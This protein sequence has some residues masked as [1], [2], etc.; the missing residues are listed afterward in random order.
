[1][2]RKR[3]LRRKRRPPSQLRLPWWTQSRHCPKKLKLAKSLGMTK[4]PLFIIINC[5]INNK[6]RSKWPAIQNSQLWGSWPP[7]IIKDWTSISLR[8]LILMISVMFHQIRR[9]L[10][11]HLAA[12]LAPIKS[13]NYR[14]L[15][16]FRWRSYQLRTLNNRD[17]WIFKKTAK[18]IL[19]CHQLFLVVEKTPLK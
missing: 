6:A 18:L 11:H 9:A 5:W 16:I 12:L 10:Y 13:L 17:S 4:A 19:F 1:M 15:K 2:P 14:N 7:P 3:I 8:S